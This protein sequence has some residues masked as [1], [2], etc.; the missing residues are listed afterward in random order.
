MVL[1]IG[2]MRVGKTTLIRLLEQE[3]LR[4]ASERML[5]EPAHL[6]FV[7][8]RATGPGSGRFDWVDFYTAVL[9]QVNNPVLNR[10]PSAVRV[11]DMRDAMAEALIQNHPDHGLLASA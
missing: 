4:R 1:V 8:V 6:P 9:R 3:L 10:K 7:R 5:R 2:P 11:R